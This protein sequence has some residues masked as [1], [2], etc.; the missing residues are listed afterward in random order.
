MSTEVLDLVHDLREG[1]F[2]RVVILAG[3]GISVSA[4]LPDFRSPGGLYDQLRRNQG[5]AAPESVFTAD[6]MLE[7][8]KMFYE[9]MGMLRTESVDPTPTHCFIRLLQDKGLLMRCFTQNIDSLERKVGVVPENIVEAHGTLGIVRCCKC[10]KAHAEKALH[11]PTDPDGLPRCTGCRSQLRPGIVFFGEPLNWDVAKV[12]ADLGE[13]DLVIVMGTSLSVQPFAG[14]IANVKSSCAILV[15]NRVMPKTLASHRRRRE[16]T[17]RLIGKPP[18]RKEAFMQG[19]CDTSIRWL[20]KALGWS[21][22]LEDIVSERKWSSTAQEA[23][24]I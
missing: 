14:I 23:L 3:A 13:A 4:N 7:R 1:C 9:V 5:L 18:L 19:D 6:F 15:V 20:A 24:P 11:E 12:K 22:E 8:P 10:G 21:E 17:S 16:L 2:Q